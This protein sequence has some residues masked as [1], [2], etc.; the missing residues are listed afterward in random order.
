MITVSPPLAVT[1]TLE[2]GPAPGWLKAHRDDPERGRIGYVWWSREAGL[3]FISW[4]ELAR[5]NRVTEACPPV[6]HTHAA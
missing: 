4:Y 6:Q 5:L 1:V 2:D 3:T